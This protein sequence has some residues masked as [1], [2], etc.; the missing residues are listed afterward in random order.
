MTTATAGADL[1]GANRLQKACC[2][3]QLV[4]KSRVVPLTLKAFVYETVFGYIAR[5]EIGDG[6]SIYVDISIELIAR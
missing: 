4:E 5:H 2:L 3:L 6:R 1:E